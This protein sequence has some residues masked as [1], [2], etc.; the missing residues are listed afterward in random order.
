MWIK[1][2]GVPCSFHLKDAPVQMANATQGYLGYFTTLGSVL[3]PEHD[4][5][6]HTLTVLKT[7]QSIASYRFLKPPHI[8]VINF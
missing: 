5:I 3:T 2:V 1:C 4:S 7:I 6:A 8:W